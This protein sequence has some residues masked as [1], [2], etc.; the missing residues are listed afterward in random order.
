MVAALTLVGAAPSLPGT[1]ATGPELPVARSEV[2]IATLDDRIYVI[3]GYANGNVDQ[4][5]VEVYRGTI[6][7]IGGEARGMSRAFTTNEGYDPATNLWGEYAPLLDGRHGTGAAVIGGR[8]FVPAGAP[9]P[10]GSR[11]SNTLLIYTLPA[12][13]CV[14]CTNC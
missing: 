10:G 3:G 8:L 2:A 14:D 4:S 5:L 1:W 9:V 13:A 7:A 6:L 12:D 11:Q